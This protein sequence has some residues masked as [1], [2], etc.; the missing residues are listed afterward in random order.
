MKTTDGNITIDS[1]AKYTRKIS[2]IGYIKC[3]TTNYINSFAE[4]MTLKNYAGYCIEEKYGQ[5]N[6][7][8]YG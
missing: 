1:N 5:W 2:E 4:K 6:Q 7:I 8:A 3:H